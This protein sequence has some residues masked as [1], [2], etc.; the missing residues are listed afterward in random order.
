MLRKYPTTYIMA[1][2]RNGTLY[3][4]VTSDPV[5]RIFEHKESL[6]EGFTEKYKCH[7]LV[8]FECHQTMMSAIEREKKIKRLS[9]RKKIELIQAMNS[10]WKDLYSSIVW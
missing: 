6:I 5:K 7:S 1:S 8:F 4:G 10:D 3:V 9:R 2:E